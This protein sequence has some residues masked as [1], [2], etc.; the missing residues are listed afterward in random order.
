[1]EIEGT[2][3]LL[4]WRRIDPDGGISFPLGADAH[5]LLTYAPDGY[6]S[7]VLTAAGRP[8]IPGGDPLGGDTQ[9]RAEAYSTCLAYAGTWERQGDTV[10]HRIED[11]LF[12]NWSGAVEPR[13]AS[14]RDGQLV[15]STEPK[16]GGAINEIAW[17]RPA[18]RAEA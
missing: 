10:V 18:K 4:A 15:L 2:W 14:D 7:V 17:M 6:M 12:P 8:S 5:G 1:M 9:N 11:S 16:P 3:Q 13:L